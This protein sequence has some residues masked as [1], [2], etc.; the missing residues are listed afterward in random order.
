MGPPARPSS[1]LV[2]APHAVCPNEREVAYWPG[3]R[4]RCDILD[5]PGPERIKYLPNF[6]GNS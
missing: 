5:H 3:A 4:Y 2:C 6:D 1:L